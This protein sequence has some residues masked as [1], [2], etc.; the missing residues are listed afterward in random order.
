[1]FSREFSVTKRENLEI[2]KTAGHFDYFSQKINIIAQFLD[3][4]MEIARFGTRGL[5]SSGCQKSMSKV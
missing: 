5:K 2:F 3:R 1:M 4:A